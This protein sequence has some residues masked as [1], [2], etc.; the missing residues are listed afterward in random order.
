MGG[1]IKLFEVDLL[2]N[3]LTSCFKSSKYSSKLSSVVLELV[4]WVFIF[5]LLNKRSDRLEDIGG[6][7]FFTGSLFFCGLA[8]SCSSS[9]SSSD[10]TIYYLIF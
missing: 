8:V 9:L 6:L 1:D 7:L 2:Q 5:Y 4:C 3:Y 10:R